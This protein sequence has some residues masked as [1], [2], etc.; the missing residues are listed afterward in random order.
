MCET[1]STGCSG[2]AVG[3]GHMPSYDDLVALL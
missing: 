3:V 2:H 1:A